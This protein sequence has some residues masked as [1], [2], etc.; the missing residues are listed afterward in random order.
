M[1]N[2]NYS[3]QVKKNTKVSF[4]INENFKYVTSK[5]W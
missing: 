5:F 4:V 1:K 2:A 3:M